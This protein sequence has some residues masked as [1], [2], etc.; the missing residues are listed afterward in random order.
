MIFQLAP[1][2]LPAHSLSLQSPPGSSFV[3]AHPLG[4][5]RGCPHLHKVRTGC[6]HVLQE[7][8]HKSCGRVGKDGSG[9]A[10][11]RLLGL[12]PGLRVPGA[13]GPFRSLERAPQMWVYTVRAC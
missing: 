11:A 9:E 4:P 1:E 6:A 7:G 12:G 3:L 8:L 10:G 2:G 5:G 13:K